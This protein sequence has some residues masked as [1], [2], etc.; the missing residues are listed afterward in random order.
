MLTDT[1]GTE[2]NMTV[3]KVNVDKWC[4]EQ[5]KMKENERKVGQGKD[6]SRISSIQERHCCVP[7]RGDTAKQY[8]K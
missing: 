8:H 1:K 3:H 4:Q 6:T 7:K 2:K 5:G